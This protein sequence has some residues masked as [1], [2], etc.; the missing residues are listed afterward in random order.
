[1]GYKSGS[2]E[3]RIVQKTRHTSKVIRSLQLDTEIS[4]RKGTSDLEKIFGLKVFSFPKSVEL[5]K[6]FI[7]ISAGDD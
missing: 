4:S 5:L 1:M 6:R 2:G 7:K 3:F